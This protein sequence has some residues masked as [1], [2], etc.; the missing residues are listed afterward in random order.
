M[1]KCLYNSGF[2]EIVSESIPISDNM[3]YNSSIKRL[4][5]EEL[6]DME[7]QALKDSI[8]KRVKQ[9]VDERTLYAIYI[10]ISHYASKKD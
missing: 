6:G 8:I 1:N 9:I 5:E 4:N 7:N 10:F 3:V 2:P